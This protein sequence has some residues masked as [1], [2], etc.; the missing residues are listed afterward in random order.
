MRI[1]L[2]GTIAA[3]ALAMSV[4]TAN[5]QAGTFEITRINPQA[6]HSTYHV[7]V[8]MQAEATYFGAVDPDDNGYLIQTFMNDNSSGGGLH[9]WNNPDHWGDGQSGIGITE[10]M[11][12][13]C[14]VPCSAYARFNRK[15]CP[16]TYNYTGKAGVVIYHPGSPEI[17]IDYS[18]VYLVGCYTPPPPPPPPPSNGG[19]DGCGPGTATVA[20]M[21]SIQTGDILSDG[22]GGYTLSRRDRQDDET[23]LREEWAVLSL[24][25][26]ADGAPA[27]EVLSSSMVSFGRAAAARAHALPPLDSETVLLVVE[28]VDHPRNGRHIATPVVRLRGSRLAGGSEPQ[29]LVVQAD[30]AKSGD[31]ADL[32]VL[33]TT[34]PVA[35]DFL[36][37]LRTRLVLDFH[38]PRRHR[39]ISYVILNVGPD[40]SIRSSETVL[41]LCCCYFDDGRIWCP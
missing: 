27:V 11:I 38:G 5:L 12:L 7:A 10:G 28:G 3:C 37:E 40:V 15:E 29:K 4:P 16:S 23:Y 19:D 36:D 25:P 31:L 34:G 20:T 2:K 8:D 22:A 6:S 1:R 17:D 21:T 32:T 9:D 13:R 26:T 39:A 33:H 18:A 14:T 24:E 41:P 30:F 35:E